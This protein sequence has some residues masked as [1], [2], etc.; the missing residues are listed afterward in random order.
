MCKPCC[1]CCSFDSL[2]CRLR[3]LKVF[4]ALL[5]L[6]GTVFA[7]AG[8]AI[9]FLSDLYF[10]VISLPDVFTEYILYAYLVVTTGIV[11]LGTGLAAIYIAKTMSDDDCS[12]RGLAILALLTIVC[13]MATVGVPAW[14][15]YEGGYFLEIPA[16]QT[17][18]NMTTSIAV[19]ATPLPVTDAQS[20]DGSNMT[21]SNM[22][23]SANETTSTN[24]TASSNSTSNGTMDAGG[25]NMTSS[26]MT[27]SANETTS[28][29][30]TASSNS[31][32]NGT[33]DAGGS[34]MTSSNMTS[35][36]N[37]TT[38]TN[39]TASSNSTSNE[40]MDAGGANMTSSNMTSSANETTSTN[41]T[42]SSNSTSN[43][44]MD[45]GGA[46]MTSSNMTS[47]NSTDAVS[48]TPDGNSTVNTSDST[49]IMTTGYY[50]TGNSTG[51]ATVYAPTREP[52]DYDEW[53]LIMAPFGIISIFAF[54]FIFFCLF[55]FCIA[56]CCPE[57]SEIVDDIDLY[58]S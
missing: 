45:A 39:A 50:T 26:N 47:D 3:S 15:L 46:N 12:T 13:S 52:I 7:L 2:G 49:S 25:S 11:A 37:E 27:S 58:K 33:M 36:A 24:A 9:G 10:D 31:T 35:S 55:I 43:E 23:S 51:N 57:R 38:S 8:I 41:A 28:T 22:T 21:S 17:S 34:N 48:T 5:F 32:S 18:M 1:R 29:N 42:A 14:P 19:T 16:A 54:I 56:C 6:F 53:L 44:T 30:A 4:G 40:T 20:A